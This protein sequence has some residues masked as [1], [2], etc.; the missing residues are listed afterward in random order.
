MDFKGNTR[1][2]TFQINDSILSFVDDVSLTS[3]ENLTFLIAKNRRVVEGKFGKT[4]REPIVSILSHRV[5]TTREGTTVEKLVLANG[6]FNDS[7]SAPR[8]ATYIRLEE[9]KDSSED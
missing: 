3:A 1:T 8:L 2:T 5:E 4:A 7:K 6:L 9:N